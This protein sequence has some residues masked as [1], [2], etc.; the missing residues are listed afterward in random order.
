MEGMSSDAED[1]LFSSSGEGDH[2]VDNFMLFSFAHHACNPL[3]QGFL[4]EELRKVTLTWR[5]S[6]WYP[7]A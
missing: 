1:D 5:V 7:L 2:N 6:M 3:L 4:L